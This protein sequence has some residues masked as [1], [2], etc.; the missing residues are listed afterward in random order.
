MEKEMNR[1]YREIAETVN[2]MIPEDWNKFYF[3]AQISENG[4]GTYFFYNTLENKQY[5]Y[6]VEIPFKYQ[7]D[8][9]EFER[10][11]DI[12]YKLSK[13][14]RNVFKDNQQ[15]LWYSFTISLESSGK[16]KLHYN[17]T[18][19]FDTE[20]SFSDQMIIWKNKYLGEVPNDVEYKALIDKYHSEFPNNPI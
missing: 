9:D 7:I 1:L 17:Y 19:W 11:E 20:Y 16:F 13:E 12:L 8:E 6:S 3:Y 14:L 5:K 10:K 4:G 18:N 2:E 15:E